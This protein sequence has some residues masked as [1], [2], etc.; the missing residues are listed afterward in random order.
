MI[1][2]LVA[3]IF[4]VTPDRDIHGLRSE[5][6]KP[7]FVTFKAPG[8]T[9]FAAWLELT[10]EWRRGASA[11]NAVK[12]VLDRNLSRTA[13]KM[14]VSEDPVLRNVHSSSGVGLFGGSLAALMNISADRTR[15]L[16]DDLFGSRTEALAK[17]HARCP[18]APQ[19][20]GPAQ[21]RAAALR[22]R[23][24][25]ELLAKARAQPPR[26]KAQEP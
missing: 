20:P 24:A 15:R 16:A 14:E 13:L 25:K 23:A 12:E 22:Q 10:I 3:R 21:L 8:S 9:R 4:A 7:V 11:R 26:L 6:V 17:P 19:E 2:Q 5:G 1:G 18:K